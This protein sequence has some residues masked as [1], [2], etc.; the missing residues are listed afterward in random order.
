MSTSILTTKFYPPPIPQE[1]VFRPRLIEKLMP[2]LSHR[3]TLIS[4]PAG[5]GKTTLLSELVQ[6]KQ[7]NCAWIS[8]DSEDND[9]V[10]FWSYFITAIHNLEPDVGEVALRLLH[11]L[12]SP[13]IRSVLTTILN[14]LT[15]KTNFSNPHILIFD[16]YNIIENRSIQEDMTFLIDHLPPQLRLVIATRIDPPLPLTRL[17][18]RDHLSEIRTEE[19][20]FTYVETATLLNE[21]IGLKL[22]D[23]DIAVINERTVGWVASLQMAAIS[24]QG[25]EDIPHFI[26]DFS[27]SNRRSEERR[28]GKECT[29]TCRSRWSPYH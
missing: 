23:K 29:P 11:S 26:R 17:R 28:V 9:P 22:T 24:M 15:A 8:L 6:L 25:R 13:S 12:Q 27:G 5:Y 16:H 2:G 18:S 3:L 19:L 4:A 10:G 21:V 20:R 14:E 1:M 7:M